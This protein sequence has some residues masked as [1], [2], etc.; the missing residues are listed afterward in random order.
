MNFG[1]LMQAVEGFGVFEI[2]CHGWTLDERMLDRLVELPQTDQRQ[3]PLDA[4]FADEKEAQLYA[5]S[6]WVLAQT[7]VG[8]RMEW[9]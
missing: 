5:G 9:V 7:L 4:E 3:N 1:V 6:H 8:W 2:Q